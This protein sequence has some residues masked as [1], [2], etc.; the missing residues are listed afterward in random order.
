MIKQGQELQRQRLEN[1]Q[2]GDA[3]AT[4]T[5]VRKY[6]ERRLVQSKS[7][8]EWCAHSPVSRATGPTSNVLEQA[9][10]VCTVSAA[11]S[12]S[13]IQ[14]ADDTALT[15]SSSIRVWQGRVGI[16]VCLAL[17]HCITWSISVTFPSLTTSC[18]TRV[19]SRQHRV[20]QAVDGKRLS[21]AV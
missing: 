20:Y 10:K 8:K 4:S 11:K 15:E 3:V 17:L 13:C 6:L 2:D 12:G 14:Q 16:Q 19:A 9:R 5:P 21:K 7:R 1:G 18:S